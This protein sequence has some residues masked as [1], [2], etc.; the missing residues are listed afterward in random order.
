[1]VVEKEVCFHEQIKKIGV[2]IKYVYIKTREKKIEK[3]IKMKKRRT[4]KS[5]CTIP[6]QIRIQRIQLIRF[7][8]IIKKNNK[9]K[10]V[11]FYI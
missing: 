4:R 6:I 11:L 7:K 3:N 2:D 8:P 5:I 1:M 9:E 10:Y